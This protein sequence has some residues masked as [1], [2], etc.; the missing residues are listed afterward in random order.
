MQKSQT[1]CLS[2]LCKTARNL[3]DVKNWLLENVHVLIGETTFPQNARIDLS[4]TIHWSEVCGK[5]RESKG[6]E[7]DVYLEASY[8]MPK[9]KDIETLYD[10]F[11]SARK[12]VFRKNTVLTLSLEKWPLATATVIDRYFEGGNDKNKLSW[13]RE[14]EILL[15]AMLALHFPK[16]NLGMLGDLKDSGLLPTGKFGRTV[17]DSVLNLLFSSVDQNIEHQPLP[18]DMNLT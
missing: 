15:D 11:D 7:I 8:A 12:V 2:D 3:D 5:A 1:T 9:I 16:F 13:V 10:D 4:F 6:L 18:S 14:L 17:K